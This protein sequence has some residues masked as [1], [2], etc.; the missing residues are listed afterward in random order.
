MPDV[1]ALPRKQI[2]ILTA[3]FAAGG[4]ALKAV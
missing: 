2:S 1:Q 3:R 4:N